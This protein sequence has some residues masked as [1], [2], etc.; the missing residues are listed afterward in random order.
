MLQ[1]QPFIRYRTGDM[2]RM[3][4]APCRDGIT[5]G[6]TR[7]AAFVHSGPWRGAQRLSVSQMD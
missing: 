1:A 4:P 5:D 3:S 6:L 7:A 2:V